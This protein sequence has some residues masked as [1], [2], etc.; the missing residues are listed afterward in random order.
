[1]NTKLR[2]R[3]LQI[4]VL[5]FFALPI[6]IFLAQLTIPVYPISK[7]EEK[8]ENYFLPLLL[9]K[10]ERSS[11]MLIVKTDTQHTVQ[12]FEWI[13]KQPLQSPSALLYM[14]ST[15]KEFSTSDAL[16]IGRIEARG[17]HQFLVEKNNYDQ[18]I[19]YDFIHN[20]VIDTI[21]LVL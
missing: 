8:K 21:N 12:S 2:R 18:L 17:S 3:H 6:L 10:Y 11:Y 13:N 7:L 15:T 1:M 14:T 9:K 16:L 20:K 4:W 19:V 5:L